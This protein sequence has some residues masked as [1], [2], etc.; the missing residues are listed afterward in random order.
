[1]I[2]LFRGSKPLDGWEIAPEALV[3][4]DH[5]K[6]GSGAFASVYKGM[7]TE[8]PNIARQQRGYHIEIEASDEVAVK[9]PQAMANDACRCVSL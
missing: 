6:L 8:L 5:Q 3:V 4:F 9:M 7:L 2:K 1:M